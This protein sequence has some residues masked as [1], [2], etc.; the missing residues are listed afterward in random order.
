MKHRGT[1]TDGSL[2]CV[3]DRKV[4]RPKKV[5]PLKQPRSG[6]RVRLVRLFILRQDHFLGDNMQHFAKSVV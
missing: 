5:W 4:L 1:G 3:I 2:F 6:A